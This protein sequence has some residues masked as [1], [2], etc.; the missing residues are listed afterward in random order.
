MLYLGQPML[1]ECSL[2]FVFAL[3][4]AL[5]K[6]PRNSFWTRTSCQGVLSASPAL[7][8]F[9]L[10]FLEGFWQLLLFEV[11]LA[12]APVC[13]C[14]WLLLR[15]CAHLHSDDAVHAFLQRFARCPLVTK[16]VLPKT[17][18]LHFVAWTADPVASTCRPVSGSNRQAK[19]H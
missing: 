16:T 11:G 14:W 4:G 8:L 1:F 13:F 7:I 15:T 3:K 9:H 2:E 5:A 12:F 10:P 18:S 19:L 17:S 6:L